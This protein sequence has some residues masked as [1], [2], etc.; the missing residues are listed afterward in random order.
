MVRLS[1][2]SVFAWVAN[3]GDYS[4]DLARRLVNYAGATYCI[5]TWSNSVADWSCA[6]CKAVPGFQ[7]ITLIKGDGTAARVLVGYDPELQARVVAFMG[8]NAEIG[9]WIA[10]VKLLPS[11]CYQDIGCNGCKC[12]PGFLKT[13]QSVSQQVYDAVSSLPHGSLIITG[14]SLG[15]AQAAHCAVDMNNRGLVPDHVYTVGQPRAGNDAFANFYDRLGFD[16]WRVTHHRDPVPHLPWRG[17]GNYKQVLR[18]V[19]YEDANADAP[20]KICDASFAED[21][22]CADQ[23]NDELT[24]LHVTD[25]WNYLG[26]SFAEGVLRCTFS[27]DE[28]ALSV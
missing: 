19:Y 8:T 3:A 21:P 17:L 5:D 25:H 20:T 9:T 7:N 1:A 22:T 2:L 27:E 24:I 28:Q 23:F 4:H 11:S 15:A 12:H 10:D 6:P 26:F 16:N 14:H 13:Y 18:E